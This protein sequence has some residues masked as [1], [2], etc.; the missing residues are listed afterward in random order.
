MSELIKASITGIDGSGKSTATE[1]VASMLGERH[2]IG[3]LSTLNYPSYLL[4]KG[5]RKLLHAEFSEENYRLYQKAQLADKRLIILYTLIA[6]TIAQGR[7][8]EPAMERNGDLDFIIGDRDRLV[9]SLVMFGNYA[10]PGLPIGLMARVLE[11]TTGQSHTD[12]LYWLQIDPLVAKSRKDKLR[13]E[14]GHESLEAL[15][16]MSRSYKPII[17]ALLRM[18][19]IDDVAFLDTKANDS[20]TIAG[21]IYRRL[22]K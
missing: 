15:K 7:F 12:Q 21:I 14:D 20:E 5:T 22:I 11:K 10:F 18:G 2:A 17:Q 6:H 8:I 1:K 13:K 19:K 16:K 4:H 3:V 9:D